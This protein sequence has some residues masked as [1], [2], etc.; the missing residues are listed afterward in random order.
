VLPLDCPGSAAIDAV[1]DEV[2]ER[3]G[4]VALTRAVLL[5]SDR[6]GTPVGPPPGIGGGP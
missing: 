2:R 5:G 6:A 3:F 4:P 1:L